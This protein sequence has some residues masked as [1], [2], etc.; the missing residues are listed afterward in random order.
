ML[1]AGAGDSH[2]VRFLKGVVADQEGR[3]LAGE[4]DQG[5]GV[6]IRRG[7]ARDRVGGSGSGGHDADAH[8]ARGPGVPIRHVDRP[9]LVAHEKVADLFGIVHQGVIDVQHRAAGIT[10][11]GIHSLVP[12]TFDQ[13][14]RARFFQ[15]LPP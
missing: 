3:N 10:E 1:G 4:D 12:Q 7:Q 13:D 2:G 15:V 9:L 5:D 14:L 8:F 6:H 11:Y